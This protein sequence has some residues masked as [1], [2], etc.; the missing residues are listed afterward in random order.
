L[1]ITRYQTGPR[2]SQAVAA[3]GLL[4]TAGQVAAGDDV[5]AQTRAILAQIDALLTAAGTSKANLVSASIW[6]ADMAD[7]AE[8]NAVWEQWVLPSATPARATVGAPLAAPA[9]RVEIAVVAA[10]G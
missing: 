1:T 7:F 9:Y 5:G 6:L 3:A 10:L 4:F 2:M 8:M